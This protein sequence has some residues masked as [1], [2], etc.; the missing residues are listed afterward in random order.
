M[1][2]APAQARPRIAGLRL[3]SCSVAAGV[4]ADGEA[5]AGAWTP[6]AQRQDILTLVLGGE[7]GESALEGYTEIPVAKRWSI[8]AAPNVIWD[9]VGLARSDVAV[10]A[11][12]PVWQG[13]RAV[14]ALQAGA[15][16]ASAEFGAC[17]GAGLEARALAGRS[18]GRE[19]QSGFINL[20]A[21]ARSGP[22]PSA[23]MEAAAGARFGQRWLLMGQT[24]GYRDE[25]G[26]NT[27]VQLSLVHGAQAQRGVQVGYRARLADATLKEGALV[28]AIWSRR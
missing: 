8:V 5:L 22:C 24:F 16:W 17:A 10:S 28:V 14:A 4:V 9:T 19:G 11:K 12:R 26:E 15:T 27:K 2:G 18:L 21:A 1:A 25:F 13:R 7:T 6:E 23:R 20:E 3:L